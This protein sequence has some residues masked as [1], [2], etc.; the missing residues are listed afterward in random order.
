MYVEITTILFDYNGVITEINKDENKNFNFYDGKIQEVCNIF[1]DMINEEPKTLYFLN[2]EEEVNSTKKIEEGRGYHYIHYISIRVKKRK[3]IISNKVTDENCKYITLKYKTN[4]EK[5]IKIFGTDF[6]KNNKQNCEILYEN[7]KYDL[8]EYFDIENKPIPDNILE[9]KLIVNNYITNMSCM[10][11][12]CY[13]LISLPDIH[14][15]DT[16]YAYDMHSLFSN[17]INLTEIDYNISEWN[18]EN[19]EDISYLFCE[20]HSLVN[21]PDISKWNI[22]KVKY[23][24]YL[25][26]SCSKIKILPNISKWDTSNVEN[27]NYLFF[28]CISLSLLPD[29]SI[30]NTSNL[31]YAEEVFGNCKSLFTLPDISK[32]DMNN[33]ISL[34]NIFIGCK[35]LLCL[36]DISKW[37][38]PNIKNIQ[39]L[40]WGCN[41]LNSIPDISKWN[42]SK[43]TD[44]SFL[45]YECSSLVSLPDIS[46][47]DINKIK[48]IGCMFTGCSSLTFFPDMS[49]QIKQR[50]KKDNS[51]YNCINLVNQP[52]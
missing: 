40:F 2:P 17:C 33:V 27:I 38:L 6:V 11:L 37:N 31:K 43:V 15:L 49:N 34:R 42:I 47:W 1:A 4:N 8:T 18:T 35:N 30:W 24:D 41:S 32:C 20:C 19:C 25:F 29:I 51:F 9:I 12:N 48:E 23:M 13:N 16:S 14:K 50:F 10:F 52:N 46:K 22:S 5:R 21:I 3:N 44:V 45:F 36:P 7:K 28:K 26:Y 39:G